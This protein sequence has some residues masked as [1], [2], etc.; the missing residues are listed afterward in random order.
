VPQLFIALHYSKSK[1]YKITNDYNEHVYIGSTCDT[2]SKRFSKHKSDSSCKTNALYKL[3][4]EIGFERFRIELI[5]DYPCEDN[6]Q[7][8][9]KKSEYIRQYEK[10]LN[11]HR[12]EHKEERKKQ[13]ERKNKK[14]NQK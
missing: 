11:L 13:K 14:S 3:I 2:L 12:E 9:Q 8:R 10:T 4:N 5:C 1:I 7:L 6:Y